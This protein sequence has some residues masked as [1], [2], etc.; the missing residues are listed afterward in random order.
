MTSFSINSE[1]VSELA[2]EMYI[3]IARSVGL[4]EPAMRAV[5]RFYRD[6]GV[7]LLEWDVDTFG[8]AMRHFIW[9]LACTLQIIEES[10]DAPDAPEDLVSDATEMLTMLS[11][12]L[13]GVIDTTEALSA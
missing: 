11:A 8:P 4:P 12:Y 1:R 9:G 6:P 3:A 2:G 10:P 7:N 5:E 13:D